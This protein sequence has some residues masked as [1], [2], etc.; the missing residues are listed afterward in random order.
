MPQKTRLQ[1]RVGKPRIL[2]RGANYPS[3]YRYPDGS[4]ILNAPFAPKPGRLFHIRSNDGGVTWKPCPDG[5]VSCIDGGMATLAD[6]TVL[7]L[8]AKTFPVAGQPNSFSGR[9]WTSNDNWRTVHGPRTYHVTAP[10]VHNALGDDNE[11][12]PGPFFQSR[13]QVQEDGTLLGTMYTRFEDG[14][15]VETP[16]GPEWKE[17]TILVRSEDGGEHWSYVSTIACVAALTNRALAASWQEGFNENGIARLNDSRLLCVMRTGTFSGWSEGKDTYHDLSTTV[18]RDGKYYDT[19]PDATRP[20]YQAFSDDNGMTWSEP[21]SAA[22]ARGACPRLLRMS[23]GV[24]V[25]GYGRLAQQTQGNAILFSLDEGKTWQGETIISPGLS[26]G[27]TDMIEAQPGRLLFVYDNVTNWP[28]E[29]TP[30]TIE[31]V[32]ITL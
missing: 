10:E 20:M 24:L 6:G 9:M 16:D 3:M 7:S 2:L 21:A 11:D 25:L 15:R 28:P 13:I 4:I 27:Y 17:R 23:N 30:D 29:Y 14:D 22:P 19:G 18:L 26:S 5:P 8:E 12:V 1:I 32:D 31:A